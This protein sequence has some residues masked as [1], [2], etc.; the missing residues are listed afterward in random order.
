MPDMLVRLYDL[1]PLEPELAAMT[2]L[3]ITLR[4]A[5]A[6][7]KHVV[8]AWVG[9]HFFPEWVSET[10]VAMSHVPIGCWLAVE[11][12]EIIGFAC[13]NTSAKGFFG[14]T[15]VS[16]AA[17]GRGVGRA[18]LIACLH[19]L[20]WEGYAYGII[21]AVGPVDFYRATVGATVIEDSTPGIYGG[22]LRSG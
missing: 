13:C 20:C 1:P 4:P 11:H 17:R 16:E 7:E 21:G 6:A 12:D 14:P 8:L 22:M 9:A 19:A 2:A 15:G 18:L 10:D 5:L 3:G